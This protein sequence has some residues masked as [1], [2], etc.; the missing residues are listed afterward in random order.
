MFEWEKIGQFIGANW[1]FAG[2]VALLIPIFKSTLSRFLRVYAAAFNRELDKIVPAKFIRRQVY[3]ITGL[4]A[5]LVFLSNVEIGVSGLIATVMV[6]A[7]VT[8]FAVNYFVPRAILEWRWPSSGRVHLRVPV[9]VA[10]G[11]P[12]IGLL[13]YLTN[14]ALQPAPPKHLYV[15]ALADDTSPILADTQ[16]TK[17]EGNSAT[18][19]SF[20]RNPL[21]NVWPRDDAVLATVEDDP[22]KRFALPSHIGASI[23]AIDD[24]AREKHLPKLDYAGFP[25]I[26]GTG[27]KLSIGVTYFGRSDEQHSWLG[28]K[29]DINGSVWPAG[30][31]DA[32]AVGAS[33]AIAQY[34]AGELAASLSEDAKKKLLVRLGAVYCRALAGVLDRHDQ[35]AAPCNNVSDVEK[36]LDGFHTLAMV[37]MAAKDSETANS[38]LTAISQKCVYGGQV[39]DF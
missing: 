2:L 34:V 20:L 11:I 8:Y 37:S 10:L 3:P 17:V 15:S 1:Q 26:R 18:V 13:T 22:A 39:C 29:P 27:D 19:F 28:Y 36:G 7:T 9:I 5:S 24:W 35:T 25:S 21:A 30:Y 32:A 16:A 33:L 38:G 4:A 12:L 31:E 6:A 23:S 14:I